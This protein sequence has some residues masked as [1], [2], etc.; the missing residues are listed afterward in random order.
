MPSAADVCKDLSST[1]HYLY[2]PNK[3]EPLNSWLVLDLPAIL[4]EVYGTLFSPS[5]N[6]VNK[7]GLQGI[8]ELGIHFSTFDVKMICNVLIAMDFCIEVDPVILKEEILKLTSDTN[9]CHDF[10]FFPALVSLKRSEVFEAPQSDHVRR[11]LC[12]QFQADPNH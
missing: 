6:I 9:D 10:L 11:T 12:W 4:H 8:Q 7:F 3:E 1:G 5:K 2:L